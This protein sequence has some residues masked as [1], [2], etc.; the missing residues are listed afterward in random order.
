[1]LV[2]KKKENVLGKKAI[3]QGSASEEN[4]QTL[5]SW[6]QKIEQTTT[7][8]SSRLSA[9]EKRLS[10]GTTEQ[11]TGNPIGL[12]GP[13][14]TLLLNVKHKNTGQLARLLDDEL[15]LLHNEC[16]HQQQEANG[17][18]EQIQDIEKMNARIAL[19][20]QAVQTTISKINTVMDQHMKHADRQEPFVMH[21]GALEIPIEFTGVIGGLLAFIVAI[22]VLVNQKAVLLSPV[23]LFLVGAL[24]LGCTLIKTV[25]SRTR[26]LKYPSFP[27]PL[28]TPAAQIKQVASK[29]KE[30]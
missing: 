16:V 21:V 3:R 24:F 13:V 11:N 6:I 28:H 25:R 18:K 14:E 17:F 5:R 2:S 8:V 7:S 10:G 12:E 19:D 27:M 26:T 29:R 22:L 4:L 15:S 9:V 23:F 1:M 30:G 20:L